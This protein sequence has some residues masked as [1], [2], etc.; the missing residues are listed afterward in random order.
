MT[1]V[2]ADGKNRCFGGQLGKEFYGDYHDHEWGVPLHDDRR[3][4][5]MLILEG[6]QAG[7][8]WET[9][10]KRR[11]GYRKAFH[12]FDPQKVAQMTDDQLEFLL[13]NPEIIRNRLKVFGARKNAVVYLKIQQEFGSF[14]HYLWGFVKGQPIKNHWKQFGDAPTSTQI[15]DALSKDLKKRGMTFVGSTI[16][17]AYL[18][19]VGMVNDHLTTCWCYEP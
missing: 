5:E 13:Q 12:H 14:D 9:I 4:F 15:S 10:L 8:S 19:A 2:G 7:L 16:I 18:Q 6:A 1:V 17:Y 11:E 3:L